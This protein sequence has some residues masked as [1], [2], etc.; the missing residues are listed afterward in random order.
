MKFLNLFIKKHEQA[1]PL[2]CKCS[3]I[4]YNT[5]HPIQ[6]GNHWEYQDGSFF[7]WTL[8]IIFQIQMLSLSLGQQSY[9]RTLQKKKNWEQS[10]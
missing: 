6:L 4:Q 7:A 3:Y 8:K 9:D 2:Q 10:E 1:V 5:I